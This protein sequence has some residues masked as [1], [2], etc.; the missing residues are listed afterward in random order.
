MTTIQQVAQKMQTIL[1]STADAAAQEIRFVQ[2]RSKLTGANFAQTLVFG[3][4]SNPQAT[5]EELTQTA[6][7]LSVEI[8]PQRLDQRFT[9]GDARTKLRRPYPLDLWQ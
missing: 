3:W 1:S 9:S 7:T 8:G 2:R 5:L 4:L 6:A